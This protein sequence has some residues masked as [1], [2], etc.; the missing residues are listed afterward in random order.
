M[1]FS[2]IIPAYNVAPYIKECLDSVLSQSY[3]DW[4]AICVDDGSTDETLSILQ[5]YAKKDVR[6]KVYSQPN[7]KQAAA[8]NKA[9]SLCS[10][11]YVVMLDSDDILV[12]GFLEL[13][14]ETITNGSPDIVAYNAENWFPENDNKVEVNVPYSHPAY[15]TF[16]T[17]KE[18]LDY[19]VQLKHWGPTGMF[20][21]FKQD[22]LEQYHLRFLEGVY[23]EDDLFI[24]QLCFFAGKVVVQPKLVY[25]YRMRSGS[26]MHS[27]SLQR[28]YN[29][30]QVAFALETFFK[31]QNY[32]NAISR[33]IIYNVAMNGFCSFCAAKRRDLI[34][35]EFFKLTWRN[36]TWKRKCRMIYY[37]VTL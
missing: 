23:H 18:F 15:R 2:L 36:A 35:K 14:N 11:D 5:Q 22:L 20:Y 32:I 12:P 6:I 26:T 1:T 30:Y 10:G 34:T 9:F 13:L 16:N 4:E 37:F 24:S 27:F 7:Q 29:K 3:Q 19:F 17:G 25:R 28:I 33:S 21:I 8:R 31:E